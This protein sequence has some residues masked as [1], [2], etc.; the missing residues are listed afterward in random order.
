M[1]EAEASGIYHMM[2]RLENSARPP[3]DHIT[4]HSESAAEASGINYMAREQWASGIHYMTV[5]Q[6]ASGICGALCCVVDVGCRV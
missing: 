2:T 1:T 3:Q 6:W 4:A 5:E